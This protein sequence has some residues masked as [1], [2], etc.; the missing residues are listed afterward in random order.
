MFFIS[1]GGM[2]PWHDGSKIHYLGVKA[3][4]TLFIDFKPF[5]PA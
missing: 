1:P 2:F 5:N 4:N 3:F